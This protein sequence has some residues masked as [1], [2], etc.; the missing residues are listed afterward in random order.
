MEI[1]RHTYISLFIVGSVV[2]ACS[3]QYRGCFSGSVCNV[4][5]TPADVICN[6][7]LPLL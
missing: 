2:R 4:G 5:D 3:E 1:P 7:V 6:C